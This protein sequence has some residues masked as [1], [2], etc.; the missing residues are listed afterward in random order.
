MNWY[1][2]QETVGSSQVPTMNSSVQQ[3]RLSQKT[4]NIDFPLP[5]KKRIIRIELTIIFLRIFVFILRSLESIFE[6]L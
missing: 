4:E 6:D 2:R 5:N 3:K 1:S